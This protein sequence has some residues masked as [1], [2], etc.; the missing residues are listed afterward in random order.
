MTQ[1]P[2]HKLSRAFSLALYG[3][4]LVASVYALGVALVMENVPGLSWAERAEGIAWSAADSPAQ[5]WTAVLLLLLATV[6]FGRWAWTA[7]RD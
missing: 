5:Y 1:N 3:V 4:G 2:T 7:Y 6:A